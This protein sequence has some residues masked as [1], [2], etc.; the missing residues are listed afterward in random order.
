MKETRK[1]IEAVIEL[2]RSVYRSVDEKIADAVN[3][4][5]DR[6]KQFT[7]IYANLPDGSAWISD[8]PEIRGIVRGVGYDSKTGEA[9]LVSMSPDNKENFTVAAALP[10]ESLLR[11]MKFLEKLDFGE[12]AAAP[13][14]DGAPESKDTDQQAAPAPKEE[15]PGDGTA[16]KEP[17]KQ[18]VNTSAEE[19]S[20]TF[21]GH[22]IKPK[23][24]IFG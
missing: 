14:E 6:K 11:L 9:L 2:T 22:P 21:V 17:E 15:E 16:G 10:L 4:S 5:P 24:D 19:R 1:Q 20:A 13:A 3:R 12:T 8:V 23:E 7:R 18:Q